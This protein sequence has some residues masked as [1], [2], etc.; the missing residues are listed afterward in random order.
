MEKE[1][2]SCTGVLSRADL[3]GHS[4][5]SPFCQNGWDGRALLGQPSKGHPCRILILFPYCSTTYIYHYHH[6]SKNWRLILPC[7]MLLFSV[8]TAQKYG[9]N[10]YLISKR[11]IHVL[12][13]TRPSL[14]HS[15]LRHFSKDVKLSKI[16]CFN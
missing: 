6:I 2:K 5:S 3:T 15:N 1:L 16:S 13:C 14:Y 10:M 4:H 9:E 7:S 12:V 8:D 11:C